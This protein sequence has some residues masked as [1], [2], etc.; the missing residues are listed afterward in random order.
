MTAPE[1]IVESTLRFLR[2]HVPFAQMARADLEYF[3]SRARLAYFPAGTT[4]VDAATG[5][6]DALH[7]IQRGH[8][9]SADP[10]LA[11]TDVVLGPGECFPLVR[12]AADTAG[13]GSFTATEDVFCFQLGRDDFVELRRR[14]LP[15]AD[16]CAAALATIVRQSV[17]QLRHD[18]GQRA[19]EQQTLLQPLTSLVRREPVW[20]P[21]GTSLREALA[22]M[23]AE[24]VGTIVV[25]DA[26]RRPLGIFTLTDLLDRVVLADVPLDAAV[27]TV[28]TPDPGTLDELESAQDALALMAE[29]GYYQVM[30]VRGHRLVGVVSERDLFA[31][32]R[33]SMRNV[34][35]SIRSAADVPQLADAVRAIERLTDNLV[36][37]GAAAG[38]LTHTI[39]SLHDAVSRRLFE[40]LAAEHPLDGI[41]WCWLALGSEGRREQTA[42]SDQDN[43]L[44]FR[45]APADID[46]AR[47]RLLAFG[48]AANAALA[49]LG[50][51]LCSG[52]VMAGN[53][54]CCLAVEE[55]QERFASWVREPTPQA[56][57]N[58]NIWFDFRPLYGETALGER[59]RAYVGGIAADSRL[60]LRMLT[61]NALQA[62]PPLGVIR[63]FRTDDGPEGGTIDLKAQGTRIFVDAARVLALGTGVAE[64]NTAQRLRLAGRKLGVPARD[65]DA[66][67][68]AFEFLQMLRLRVQRGLLE[69]AHNSLRPYALNELDQRLLKE[70][71]RQARSLQQ[72][73]ERTFGQ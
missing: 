43:A 42:A 18:F 8:V 68:E 4:I 9:R 23:R 15:F 65:T 6:G 72:H 60:F 13:G 28:M 1:L 64:T 24:R 63:S 35:Q 57:L 37:Q 31:L 29:R 5:A 20:C 61:T 12:L 52:N 55:W 56:L 46:A 38:P 32:Q 50:I 39:A 19:I 62:E 25:A 59:L 71:L 21:A 34:L 17:A 66:T 40:V 26:E 47:D 11:G 48:R 49:T 2:Q 30:V 45:V 73:V 58:A 16:F 27:D 3:A 14:S 36:A 69:G 7:V 44:V 54:E 70:A 53:P 10:S 33:V 22:R 41:D 67:I 51:P